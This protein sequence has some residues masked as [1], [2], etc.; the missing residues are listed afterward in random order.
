MS[1]SPNDILMGTATSRLGRWL[2]RDR[3]LAFLPIAIILVAVILLSL[4]TPNFMTRRN[5]VN[6]LD[7][8]SALALLAVGITAV[9]VGGGIDLSLPANLAL[10]GVV[11]A[12]IM[13]DGGSPILAGVIM[14][15]VGVLVGAINGLAVAYFRMIPFVVTLA[16]Q[17]VAIGASTWLTQSVSIANL[18]M[19]FVDAV[20]AK[21]FGLPIPIHV[22]IVIVLILIAQVLFKSSIFGRW[23]YAVGTNSKAARVAGIPAQRV[24]FG[25]Y[26]FAG[27]CAGLAAIITVGRLMSASA[28]LAGDNVILDTIGSAVVGGVSI[29]G[30]IGNP[31]GA[32]LGALLITA[33]SNS[34]NMARVSY[35]FTLMLKGLFIIMFVWLNTL[36]RRKG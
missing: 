19:S 9:M 13:R 10:S 32:A 11:G 1:I 26:V 15:V 27:L 4:F 3:L 28:Q 7:Q 30:G 31:L 23:L 36:R 17:F 29:Y 2:T 12:I 33:I 16:M 24:V 22:I 35:Y 8:T 6:V 18:P 5:I 34:M 21:P 20:Q 14:V 25:T